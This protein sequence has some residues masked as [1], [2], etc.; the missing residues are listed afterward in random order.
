V[1]VLNSA[2]SGSWS[3]VIC[4][5]D[6]VTANAAAL[7]IKVASMSLGGSGSNDSNCGSTNGDALHA[8]ICNSVKAGVTYVVA[9]GNNGANFSGFVPAAYPEV[10]TVTAVSD[11][12]GAP[13]GT[14][15]APTCR[16]G[17]TDD[18]YATFSNY[19]GASD[20]V[21]QSH[22][23]A[24]PGV[25]ITSTWRG[26]GTNTI[27]GTSMAT[28][29]VSGVVALCISGGQCTPGGSPSST[30]SAIQTTDPS[31]GFTGDPLHSP[32]SGR[33]YGYIDWIGASAPPPAPS[34]P[35]APA[36]S[37]ATP[38]NASVT[39]A[40][41]APSS[42]GGSAITGYRIYRGE[43]S[44]SETA[45]A[46]VGNQTSFKDTTVTNGTIYWYR[47]SAVNVLGE[48]PLSN[49]L[50]ATPQAVTAPGAP[51]NFTA[52]TASFW[53]RGVQLAWS[54]P[55]SNGGSAVTGYRVY[56]SSSPGVIPSSTTLLTT[57]TG[58]SYR[59]SATTRGQT[60]YYVVTAVN[61]VGEGPAS[62]QASAKAR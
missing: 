34:R 29:H 25:C 56:R 19:A 60:Y 35:G 10:V 17:E 62:A 12:D 23:V 13:G 1:K 15:G 41:T 44:G 53:L 16:T 50:S 59:D 49:G 36:L 14:G 21:A 20:S 47:V 43:T 46:T 57:L 2:G 8:A 58:R 18:R 31:K 45:L 26:G 3:Q 28:P 52:A 27:S 37:S 48:G 40:W 4:G 61:A 42:D 55:A 9:A 51:V 22:T 33:F 30:V 32:V 5:I 24:A 11:S 39:L 6:W 7:N 38:G 54:P